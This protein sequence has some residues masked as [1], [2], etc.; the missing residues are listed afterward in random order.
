MAT[1]DSALRFPNPWAKRMAEA[2]LE[3]ERDAQAMRRNVESILRLGRGERLMNVIAMG[4][5]YICEI[6]G[7]PFADNGQPTW[8]VIVDGN[9]SCTVF[10]SLDVALLRFV[11]LR[12]ND[13]DENGC[14][15]VFA[16]RA[17]GV[18]EG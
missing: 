2:V 9:R 18:N 6:H 12:N 17:L 3:R 4:N 7:G 5:D 15:Y 13:G 11:E 8:R 10:F 16:A 14:G 1:D